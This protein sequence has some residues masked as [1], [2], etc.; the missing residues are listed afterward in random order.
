MNQSKDEEQV[1]LT[2]RRYSHHSS[3][4][5]FLKS[6]FNKSRMSLPERSASELLTPIKYLTIRESIKHQY[7]RLAHISCLFPEQLTI[8]VIIREFSILQDW[9][10]P[11]TLFLFKCSRNDCQ[12]NSFRKCRHIHLQM[13]GSSFSWPFAGLGG[14]TTICSDERQRVCESP[15]Q[16]RLENI[17]N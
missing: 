14:D 10:L 5:G 16:P 11:E 13:A 17:P 7:I 8:I 2:Q 1:D 12:Y 4:V 3:T 6:H 9:Q 15:G